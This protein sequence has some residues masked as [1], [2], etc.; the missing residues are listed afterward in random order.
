[1]H[2]YVIRCLKSHDILGSEEGEL[3]GRHLTEDCGCREPEAMIVDIEDVIEETAS[4]L[5]DTP[6]VETQT[7]V[8]CY[9]PEEVTRLID[10]SG[11]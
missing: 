3:C 5:A 1:M 7:P 10:S 8:Y 4:P 2:I 9:A 6:I 11:R